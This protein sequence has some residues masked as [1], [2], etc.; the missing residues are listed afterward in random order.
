[1]IW[2]VDFGHARPAIGM[3]QI[4]LYAAAIRKQDRQI[5]LGNGMVAMRRAMIVTR[6]CGKILFHA[7]PAFIQKAKPELRAYMPL[8]GG[9][10]VKMMRG[11]HV[12]RH[13]LAALKDLA[14][15]ELRHRR[16]GRGL[17]A[18]RGYLLAGVL[19]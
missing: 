13:M 15:A 3:L 19:R 11:G 8:G 16:A 14:K 5:M 10:A 17:L 12:L 2:R 4:A 7:K 9:K 18:E 6:R 1:M